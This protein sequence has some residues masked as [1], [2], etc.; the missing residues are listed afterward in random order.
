MASSE[1]VLG[2]IPAQILTMECYDDYFGIY[3]H[4][5]RGGSN[6]AI[7]EM[8]GPEDVI[9][10]DS[11]D[12]FLDRYLST[13]VLKYTGLNFESFMKLPRDRAEAVLKR[14]DH[15]STKEDT[16]VENMLANATAGVKK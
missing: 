9:A 7:S 5:R 4:S 16:A 11:F 12:V 10:V 6:F 14:C 2:S 8:H 13:N 15:I 1:K 3:A